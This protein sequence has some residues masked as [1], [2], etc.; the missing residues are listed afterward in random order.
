VVF[1][2]GWIGQKAAA[3]YDF[4]YN[5]TSLYGDLINRYVA[6]G[7][8]VLAPGFRGHGT[9][10]GIAAAGMEWMQAWDNGSY[11]MPSFYAVD[12]LNLLEGLA[13][14]NTDEWKHR[15]Y[16]HALLPR[17]DLDSV[18]L[19]AHSQGGDVALTVLAVAGEGSNL[20]Q[21]VHAASIWSGNIPDRFTQANTFGPMGSTL[22]AFMSGDGSWTGSATGRD[23][24]TNPNFVFPW[25]SDWINT[26]D[27]QS[28]EWT[29]QAQ[30]WSTPTVAQA[31]EDKYSEMYDTLNTC[32]DDIQT[33][34]PQTSIDSSG[35]ISYIHPREIAVAMKK[36]GGYAAT[37]WLKE[38][39]F[40]HTS[41]RDYYSLPE[42]NRELVNSINEEGGSARHFVYR[43]NTHSLKAS[44]YDWFSP[45]GTPDG[46]PTAVNRDIEFF[47]GKTPR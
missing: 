32:V 11:L 47:R 19:L 37:P 21:A 24:S 12:V 14:F 42:W 26:L 20:A 13:A 28:T 35:K 15:G 16:D 5:T 25:P 17:L 36:I 40:L 45:P 38:P 44:E 7:F 9:V 46:L 18:N 1:A 23:G 8:V 22:E 4:G 3:N 30:Q 43:H 6:A 31:L 39:L 10:D 29:W 27:T 34:R 41:D 2:H 33:A